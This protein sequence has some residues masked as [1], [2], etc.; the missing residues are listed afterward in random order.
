MI[1]PPV[2]EFVALLGFRFA[3]ASRW[4]MV[5][6]NV[7]KEPNVSI[8]RTVRN[9]FEERADSGERKFPAAPAL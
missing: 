8:S 7:L 9:A 4:G 6:L 3:D 5:A 1:R 2:E